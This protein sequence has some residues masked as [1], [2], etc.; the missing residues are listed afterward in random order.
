VLSNEER[1]NM[2]ATLKGVAAVLD[3]GELAVAGRKRLLAQPCWP[4]VQ[5]LASA[6]AAVHGGLDLGSLADDVAALEADGVCPEPLVTGDDLVAA[7]VEPG[8]IYRRV[9]DAVYDAQLEHR[10]T[11]RQQALDLAMKLASEAADG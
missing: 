5:V 3:W 1:E 10:V 11:Q 7:G 4:N 6:Y 2:R 8:P 9:L